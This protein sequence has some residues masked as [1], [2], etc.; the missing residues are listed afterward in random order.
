MIGEGQLLENI[1]LFGRVLHNHG[2][3]V[4]TRQ[5]VVLLRALEYVP[6]TN[7]ADFYH[8]SRSILVH[9]KQDIPVF[10]RIFEEFWSHPEKRALSLNLPGSLPETDADLVRIDQS[11]SRIRE[12]TPDPSDD[13]NLSLQ[14]DTSWTYSSQEILREMDFTQ[15]NPEEMIEVRRMI[16]ELL[17]SIAL[18]RSRRWHLE[19]R[20]RKELRRT[21]RKNIQSIRWRHPRMGPT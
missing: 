5:M 15:L 21:L 19:G 13:E 14:L 10:D 20:R 4:N 6:L 2:L 18:R 1:L 12:F 8:T 16:K 9:H 7:K 11:G 3:D 17:V